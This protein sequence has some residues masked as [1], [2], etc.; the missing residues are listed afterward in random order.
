MDQPVPAAFFLV[1]PGE[2][3][4]ALAPTAH[5]PAATPLPLVGDTISLPSAE[6]EQTYTVVVV[7]REFTVR[8]DGGLPEISGIRVRLTPSSQPRQRWT[9]V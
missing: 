6:G 2:E 7:V 4:D 1:R 5:W 8:A 3:D 9:A